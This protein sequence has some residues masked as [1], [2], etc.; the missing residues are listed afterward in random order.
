MPGSTIKMKSVTL[1]DSSV[2]PCKP[3][4]GYMG[5]GGFSVNDKMVVVT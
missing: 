1:I 3:L 5:R 2:V 4:L